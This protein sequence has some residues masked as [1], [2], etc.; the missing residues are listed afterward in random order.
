M[1]K[2]TI[3]IDG[4]S[5]CGKS[6]LAKQLAKEL[7]YGYIDTGA[8]FRAVALYC[9]NNGLIETDGT[10]VYKIREF[11][12]D[13]KIG[14]SYN[15]KTELN[16]ITLNDESVE[17]EIRNLTISRIVTKI[18]GIKEVRQK[19]LTLQQELGKNKAMVLDGRDIGTV[20]FPDAEL[21][22][23]MTADTNVR[24]KRRFDELKSK[25]NTVTI[26]EVKE[27]LEL[28]DYTDTTREESPLKRADDAILIDNTDLTKED[29]LRMILALAQ[30]IKEEED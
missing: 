18:S 3:A 4:Y 15:K 30:Q 26:D 8:M 24:A 13:I 1:K 2:I 5:S 19:L 16:E 20:V 28:R 17:E 23:F 9:L 12:D 7:G 22:I 29:Q 27:N 14:F 6:T 21:K 25:G 11:L 10:K